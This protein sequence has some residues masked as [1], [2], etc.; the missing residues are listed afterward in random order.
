[1]VKRRTPRTSRHM[2]GRARQLRRQSSFPERLLWSRLRNGRCG[3]IKFRR[4]HP[5]GAYVVDFFC[6]STGVVVELDGRSHEER[7]E[8]DLKRQAFLQGLGLRIIRFS[9][10]RLLRDLDG[11]VEGIWEVC[12]PSPGPSGHPLPEGEG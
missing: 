6:A 8:Y 2:T 5:L 10:D 7:G 1:M 9:N 12:I 3:G 11:V 4:Q